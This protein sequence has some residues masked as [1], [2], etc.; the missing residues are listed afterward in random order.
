M[1]RNRRQVA[2]TILP[3]F[4]RVFLDRLI[5]DALSPGALFQKPLFQ[6]ASLFR[7]K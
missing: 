4:F 6:V 7:G 2:G 3:G 1:K 5:Q